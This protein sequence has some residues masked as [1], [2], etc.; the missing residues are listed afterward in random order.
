M[1]LLYIRMLNRFPGSCI[2]RWKG[3]L[4]RLAIPFKLGTVKYGTLV[5]KQHD[6]L[7]ITGDVQIGNLIIYQL[8]VVLTEIL[9]NPV[10]NSCMTFLYLCHCAGFNE[11][12]E[13]IILLQGE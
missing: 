4:N 2:K 10:A 11:S 5:V 9:F 7:H 12:P 6:C 1:D 13:I 3:L 8:V